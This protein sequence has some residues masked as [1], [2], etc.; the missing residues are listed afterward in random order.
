VANE[1][2]N[3]GHVV[4]FVI[5]DFVPHNVHEEQEHTRHILIRFMA[6]VKS[7]LVD[8]HLLSASLPHSVFSK[9]AGVV[10]TARVQ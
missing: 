9:A 2:R 6:I 5:P 3:V 8:P 4:C 10:S 1:C 7:S